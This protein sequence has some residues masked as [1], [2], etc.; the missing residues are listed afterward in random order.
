MFIRQQGISKECFKRVSGPCHVV[1]TNSCLNTEVKQHWAW[2]ILG[3]ETAWELQV[4]QTKPKLG[5][6]MQAK[7]MGGKLF[8]AVQALGKS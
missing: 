8:Q 5:R 1:N 7:Q 4:Q 2:I 3:Y 6:S